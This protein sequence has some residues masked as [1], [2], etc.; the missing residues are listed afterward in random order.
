GNT[1]R[2]PI[3]R[4]LHAAQE[5]PHEECHLAPL[6]AGVGVRLVDDDEIPRTQEERAVIDPE[7]QVL[8]HCVVCNQDVRRL[9]PEDLAGDHFVWRSLRMKPP[10]FLLRLRG[11]LDVDVA[12][13]PDLRDAV[14]EPP[15]VL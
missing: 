9:L 15:E 3:T 5:P 10:P 2:R 8:Q 13:E 12:P 4:M 6:S 14:E 1:L 11:D 7:E